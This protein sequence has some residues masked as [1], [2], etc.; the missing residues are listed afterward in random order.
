MVEDLTAGTHGPA[1]RG[2]WAF[3]IGAIWGLLSPVIHIAMMRGGV[4]APSLDP[5]GVLLV[6]VDLPFIAAAG[7]ETAIGR[8]SPSLLEMAMVAMIVGAVAVW[9]IVRV[10][11]LVRRRSRRW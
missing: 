5:L 1:L 6:A 10:V 8:P 4:P 11:V 2:G 7:L 9:G 3:S